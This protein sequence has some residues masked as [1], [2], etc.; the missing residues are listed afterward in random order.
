MSTNC[1]LPK[2][3]HLS[4]NLRYK[5]FYGSTKYSTDDGVFHGKILYIKG[6]ITYEGLTIKKICMNFEDAVDEY[7]QIQKEILL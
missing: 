3:L 5:G 6:L 1:E 4:P 7:L 2:L